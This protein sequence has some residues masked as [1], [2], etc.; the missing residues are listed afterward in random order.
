MRGVPSLCEQVALVAGEP[1][2]CPRSANISHPEHRDFL[3]FVGSS[4]QLLNSVIQPVYNC[5]LSTCSTHDDN[6][7][8]PL[9]HAFPALQWAKWV[10]HWSAADSG[11]LRSGRCFVMRVAS[12]AERRGYPES[13][14]SIPA[15]HYKASSTSGRK[16]TQ[17]MGEC[18][19]RTHKS[20]AAHN[21]SG[22][23]LCRDRSEQASKPTMRLAHDTGAWKYECTAH[24]AW[25]AAWVF[26]TQNR[27]AKDTQV[28]SLGV[29]SA[30]KQNSPHQPEGQR[31]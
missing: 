21:P 13:A 5:T 29:S 24:G 23:A 16:L 18:R 2:F 31:G 1:R 8:R 28:G 17:Q 19:R 4:L 11:L 10:E 9:S 26:R 25:W 30:S 7:A 3:P 20:D 15:A 27:L 14:G 12:V 6:R 22:A